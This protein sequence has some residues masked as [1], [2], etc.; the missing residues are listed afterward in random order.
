MT[1]E[2]TDQK[3]LKH[4]YQETVHIIMKALNEWDPYELIEAGA[5]ENEFT[6]EATQIAAKIKKTETPTELAHV[7]SDV[8]TR[9]FDSDVFS[10]EECLPVASRILGDLEVR[11]LL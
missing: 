2:K 6:E 11:H 7:I 3:T 9:S 1:M 5:P 8:F 4:D 10:V